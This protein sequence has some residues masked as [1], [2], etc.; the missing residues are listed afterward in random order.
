[1]ATKITVD[2][3]KLKK[4]G[5]RSPRSERLRRDRAIYADH[6][7]KRPLIDPIWEIQPR[8]GPKAWKWFELYRDLG[9]ERTLQMVADAAGVSRSAVAQVCQDWQWQTRLH[10]LDKFKAEQMTAKIKRD[11]ETMASRQAT[12]GMKLQEKANDALLVVDISKDTVTVRD[13]VALA[14]VGVKIERLARGE[15]T[16]EKEKIVIALPV[17]P[18]WAKG[19]A[20]VIDAEFVEHK[21]LSSGEASGEATDAGKA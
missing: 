8:E 13:V 1:M 20:A 21:A 12:L 3:K 16:E 15:K 17:I 7:G 2:D 9:E 6:G 10:A 18:A 11:A 14:D 19:S 5:Q 4:P